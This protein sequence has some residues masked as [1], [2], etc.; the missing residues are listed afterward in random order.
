MSSPVRSARGE[1]GGLRETFRELKQRGPQVLVTGDVPEAVSRQA[2]RRLLG[3]PEEKRHRVFALTDGDAAAE[4]WFPGDRSPADDRATLISGGD[5]RGNVVVDGSADGGGEDTLV[6]RI[7]GEIRSRCPDDDTLPPAMLRVGLYSLETLL[8]THGIE[9]VRR[10]AYRL[11]GEVRRAR[12]MGHYHLPRAADA[13][14]VA[15]L[16][17][18][19]DARL[20]LRTGA[21]GP[22]QRWHLPGR[23]TTNWVALDEP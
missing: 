23:G 2:T 4:R 11:T 21:G 5:L 7:D 6:R 17:F 3:H 20:E 15:D 22:E 8:E 9:T 16:Q 19:F 10:L 1:G 14:A 13:D 18:V 12:G